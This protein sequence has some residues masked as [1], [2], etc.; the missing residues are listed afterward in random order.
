MKHY[1]FALAL[2]LSHVGVAQVRESVVSGSVRDLESREAIPSA[3]IRILGTTKG[4]STNLEGRYRIL[5]PSGM[6]KLVVSCIGYR[7][8]TLTI[9]IDT[10]D[11][12]RDVLLQVTTIPLPE[13]TVLGDI[14]NPAERVILNAIANKQKVVSQLRTYRFKAYT[15][16][17][18][19]VI[20]EQ[21]NTPDT[22]IGGLL[23]TQTE[24][25]WKAPDIYKEE[26]IARRQS[27][28]FT[29]GQNIFTVGRL[30]N[31]NDDVTVIEPHSIIGPTAPNSLEYYKFEMV[32][33]S[34]IDDKYVFR[35]RMIPKS[36][37]R[38]LFDGTISIIDGSFQVMEVDVRGNAA[39]DL[40]P[41]SDIRIRQRFDLFEHKF[42]L[43]VES[44]T[45]FNVKLSFPPVPP[46]LCEQYSLIYDYDINPDIPGSFFD[47]YVLSTLP[48]ADQK[49]STY[50][51]SVNTLPLTVDEA[52][53]V[54]RIDSIM[55]HANFVQRSIIWLTRL[56]LA[57]KDIPIS[58][59]SDFFHF[60]RVEG[61][62]LGAGF[63]F[64]HLVP[65]TT[66]TLRGGYAFAAKRTE[67]SF[68]L[69]RGLVSSNDVSVGADVY[70]TISFREG[71]E[72][73]SPGDITWLSLLDNNDPVDYFRSEGWS[74]F[75]HAKPLTDLSFEMRY[76][77]ET[78]QS[79][80]KETDY[81]FF[82]SSK[83]RDNPPIIDGI[84]RSGTISLKY[85]TRRFTET[86]FFDAEDRSQNSLMLTISAEYS[87]RSALAS[88]FQFARYSSVTNL[89][90]LTFGSGSLDGYLRLGYSTGQLPP[91]RIFD[92]YGSTNDISLEGSLKTV[93]VKEFAG[94]RIATL[95]LEHNFAS[96]PFRMIGLPLME[97]VDFL[98]TASA[99]WTGLSDESKAIQP[100]LLRTNKNVLA[101]VGFG[102][103]RLLTLFRLDFSWRL[104]E[105]TGRNF[106][107]TLGAS[108]L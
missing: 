58:S 42:W 99:A 103:G 11:F 27:A 82:G 73:L 33:T 107:L 20:R 97:N 43:P 45:T 3:N 47:Q 46:I 2:L 29:A 90:L 1:G 102:L 108:T 75:V 67:Y 105:R 89:H 100:V 7:S 39:L 54:T 64:E 6:S 56:P 12:H 26:I 63:R 62:Y 72:F 101:E 32:D 8:D 25:N 87:D 69:E 17:T 84:L 68:G 10:T 92:L 18:L 95:A 31:L 86:G 106:A 85:D 15:K 53:A 88:D 80:R 52:K 51:N 30:I 96:L 104:T 22:V 83:Y 61:A 14:R 78:E 24:G 91:Q 71:E 4:T 60:N 13:V 55:A 50:W 34:M 81:A 66:I 41:V 28:N 98:I 49:D 65:A 38:P 36:D 40:S 76:T 21:H 59:V 79:A 44:K 35:I 93:A 37:T 5:L 94:D 74:P 16:T 9:N 77:N 57:L 48:S 23:E 70:R 19:R